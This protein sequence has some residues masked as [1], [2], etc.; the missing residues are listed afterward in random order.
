MYF[1]GDMENMAPS[2]CITSGRKH[3][4]D[5]DPLVEEIFFI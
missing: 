5:T 1:V 4:Y 2:S 3:A